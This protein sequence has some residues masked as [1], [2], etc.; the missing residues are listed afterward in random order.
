MYHSL[1]YL[2][3]R[4]IQEWDIQLQLQ[5]RKI[6]LTLDNFSGHYIEYEP[7]CIKF[8]Y[9]QPGLTSHV[10]PLDAGIIHSFKA[11]YSRL[12][13][14]CTIQQDEAEEQDIYNIDILEAM[15][16]AERAWKIV[17]LS[18]IKNSWNHTKIQW[19]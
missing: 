9:F 7:K 11:H 16:L 10:Q 1:T 4:W 5:N 15:K 8:I 17:S 12:L 3:F 19:P 13:C 2:L 14:L 18:T 6:A